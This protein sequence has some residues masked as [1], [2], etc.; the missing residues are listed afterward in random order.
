MW[1]NWLNTLLSYYNVSLCLMS[2]L[3]KSIYVSFWQRCTTHSYHQEVRWNHFW[4]WQQNVCH[5]QQSLAVYC[6]Y[7]S[8]KHNS[9][10]YTERWK[11]FHSKF[12]A[13]QQFM[14]PGWLFWSLREW[15]TGQQG[16]KSFKASNQTFT[17]SKLIFESPFIHIPLRITTPICMCDISA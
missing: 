10:K 6:Q 16:V 5:H 4:I 14:D 9:C 1:N 12:P 15:S 7:C 11:Y 8:W 13:V 17:F 2:Q 3:Y